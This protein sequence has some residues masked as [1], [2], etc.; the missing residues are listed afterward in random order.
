MALRTETVR[1]PVHVSAVHKISVIEN[2]INT[3]VQ[4]VERGYF[5]YRKNALGIQT[6]DNRTSAFTYLTGL[7]EA[8]STCV[9]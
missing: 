9:D 7:S 3:P 8:D 1:L 5:M 4:H 2:I 6:N